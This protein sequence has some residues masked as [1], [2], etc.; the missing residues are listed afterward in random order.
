M[1]VLDT[2]VFINGWR[3]H[4]PPSTFPG[5]WDLI[6]AALS[7][8]RAIG[9]REVL[10]E[11]AAKD[12]DVYAWAK[13]MADVFVDPDTEVQREAG[14]LQAQLLKPGLRDNA[15]PWVIAEAKVRGLTVVTYEGT[16]FGGTKTVKASTKMPGICAVLRVRCVTLPEALGQLGGSFQLGLPVG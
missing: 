9:P 2:S 15:D 6:A 7:D 16:T 5:V 1:F 8:G 3:Y 11:L 4:Y 12:D 13:P 14:A 10:N